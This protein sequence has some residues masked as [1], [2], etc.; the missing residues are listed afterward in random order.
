MGRKVLD[1]HSEGVLSDWIRGHLEVA[2]HPFE[3]RDALADLEDRVLLELDPPLNLDGMKVTP[4]RAT[5]SRSRAALGDQPSIVVETT[6]APRATN[7]VR[8]PKRL[9]AT[10]EEVNALIQQ[11]LRRLGLEEVPAVD[12]ARWLDAAG[13]LADSGHRPGLPLRELLRA[14]LIEGADQRPPKGHGRWFVTRV[15]R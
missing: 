13:V 11:E 7:S 14:G 10:P 15:G 5:L 9:G 12:A 1:D 6:P 4:L 8:R 3:E 2:V